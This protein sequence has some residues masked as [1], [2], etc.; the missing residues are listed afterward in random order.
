MTSNKCSK[1]KMAVDWVRIWS[2]NELRPFQTNY[3]VLNWGNFL[4]FL[5]W[6]QVSLVIVYLP[7]LQVSFSLAFLMLV[8]K[9]LNLLPNL[10]KNIKRRIYKIFMRLFAF[11]TKIKLIRYSLIFLL[12]LKDSPLLWWLCVNTININI[13]LINYSLF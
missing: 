7:S 2:Q 4:L 6:F 12:T 13:L 8:L 9:E 11:K 1:E 3:W 5:S 10:L